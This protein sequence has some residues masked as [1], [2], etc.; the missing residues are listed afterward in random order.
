MG[1]GKTLADELADL[2]NPAPERDPEDD[3]LGGDATLLESE[4]EEAEAQQRNRRGKEKSLLLRGDMDMD[5]CIYSGTKS[6]RQNLYGDADSDTSEDT[7]HVEDPALGPLPMS[8]GSGN[9]SDKPQEQSEGDSDEPQQVSQREEEEEDVPHSELKVFASDGDHAQYDAQQEEDDHLEAALSE[10]K[11]ADIAKGTAVV[12]QQQLGKRFV[13]F[14][15]LLQQVLGNSNRMPRSELAAEVSSLIQAASE[16]HET[17]LELQSALESTNSAIH[18]QHDGDASRGDSETEPGVRSVEEQWERLDAGWMRAQPF[19]DASID[20]WHRKTMLGTGGAALRSKLK[21]LAQ[22]PSQ[23][24]AAIL[25]EPSKLVA[26]VQLPADA[27]QRVGEPEHEIADAN[28]GTDPKLDPETFDDSEF[29]STLL[30]EFLEQEG[31]D[32]GGHMGAGRT[33]RKRA[34]DTRASKG[35][36]IRYDVHEKLVNFMT[37][38]EQHMP[39]F[40]SQVF[41]NLFGR[42]SS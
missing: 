30:K 13:E 6:S 35:R 19:I 25:S 36:K 4:D 31:G 14:R 27:V 24:L 41:S 37:P 42:R 39:S 38:E 11:A 16:S 21:S 26:R 1:R 22:S 5:S 32:Q 12:A 34:V 3:P 40:V 7:G 33:K 20:R 10:R 18:Q 17:L 23:H 2:A 9:E 29:Y 28:P 8:G 15:I